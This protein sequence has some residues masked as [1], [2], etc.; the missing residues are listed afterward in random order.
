MAAGNRALLIS[1]IDPA[2][3]GALRFP[4]K[5]EHRSISNMVEV[6]SGYCRKK[7]RFE[8]ASFGEADN[9]SGGSL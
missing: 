9:V 7:R 4:A 8:I 3:E 2:L 6:L 1:R 5:L